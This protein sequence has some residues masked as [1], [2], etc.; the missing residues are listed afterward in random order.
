[1]LLAGGTANE[2]WAKTVT[3]HILT[4]PF[5]VRNYNNSE[6]FRTN[7]RVE[8][9]Q[10]TSEEATVG[11][12]NQF[13]SPLAKN[14]RYWAAA[15]GRTWDKLY[16][17]GHNGIKI[18]N[19][20]YYIYQCGL[21][22]NVANWEYACLSDEI[23]NPAETSSD[24]YTDIYVTYD[25]D[26]EN[27]IIDLNEGKSY[28]LAFTKDGKEK[29]VCFNRSRNNRI[30]SALGSGL[31]GDQLASDD[32]VE[33]VNDKKQLGWNWSKWGPKG[34]LLRFKFTGEDPYNITIMTSYDGPELHI[35]DAVT[36]VDGTGTVKPYAGST[37]MSKVNATS[38][39]FDVSNNRHYKISSGITDYAKWTEEKYQECWNAYYGVPETDRYD[40]WDGFYRSESPTLNAFAFLN[41][42]TSGYIFVGSKMNQGT[43]SSP[44][45][46]QPDNSGQYYTYFDNYDNDGGGRS[47]PYFKLQSLSSAL[48]FKFNV[49][50][51]Y[52]FH[53]TTHGSATTLSTTKKWSD[54]ELDERIVDHIPNAFK[55]KYVTF[56]AYSD[57]GFTQPVS[58]FQ[59]IQ[60]ANN[61]N[62]IYLKYTVSEN[63]PFEALPLNGSYQNARWYT[64]RLNTD[65]NENKYLAYDNGASSLVTTNGSGATKGSD[66]DVHQGETDGSVTQVAFM[67]DPFELRILSRSAS[68]DATANRY[69]G[70]ATD[71]TDNTT[72]NTNKTTSDIS[73]WEIVDDGGYM[74][75]RKYGSYASP[76]YIGMGSAA[77]NKP[78][79]YSSTASRIKV[80]ELEKKKYMYHIVRS[81]GSVAV[82]ASAM[83]DVGQPLYNYTHIPEVICTPFFNPA[84][85]YNPSLTFYYT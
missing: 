56:A 28:N 54:A 69:I 49:V 34:L 9:L 59:D 8:A 41:H 46:Y 31:T 75:L 58:T 1:M 52:T 33:P 83:Q 42:P 7:I 17:S 13:K 38:M 2:A 27:G 36:N 4:K 73:T 23:D 80:M 15:P 63:M 78:V 22:K 18:I 79:T 62:N 6:N 40:A 21:D 72:L 81:D 74:V 14:F 30:A 60:N 77:N 10:C 5:T 55:R 35:T 57:A 53:V 39:W 82:M 44:I 67:G 47:Q 76:M 64:M 85:G 3:Y 20:K 50:Q 16:D 26:E 68:E 70:C 29:Y 25:Y 43:G 66:S 45:I 61:G 19:T 24:A 11:L 37:L 12:P 32:F 71:A 65:V 51:E 84:L 48:S